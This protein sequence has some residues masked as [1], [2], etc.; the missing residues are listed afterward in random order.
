MDRAV[1]WA[2]SGTEWH[3][4]DGA[5]VASGDTEAGLLVTSTEFDDYEFQCEVWLAE[6]G[7]SGLFLRTQDIPADPAVHCLEFNLCDTHETYPT[8]SL[9][10]RAKAESV[11][12]IEGGWHVVSVRVEGE[13]FQGSIDGEVVLEAESPDFLKT[14][15]RRIG[16]QK[17]QGEVRFRDVK[18]RPL[19]LETVLST[20]SQEGWRTAPEGT[21]LS[22]T[23]E[24]EGVHLQGEGYYESERTYGDFVLQIEARLNA[25]DVNSGLFF[26]AEKST[27]DAPS[28]GYEMQMQNTIAEGDRTRPADYGDGFGTGAIFRRQRARYV[29]ASDKE[30][31]HITLVAQGNHFATWVN[32]LQVTDFVDDRET[33]SNPRQGRRDEAGHLSFQ[34]HDPATDITLR[35]VRVRS[36]EPAG[37]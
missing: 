8:G 31:M 22:V 1:R 7:N 10:G 20:K 19:G 36:L 4:S 35:S 6:G 24:D 15:G 21:N 29:N 12:K 17:N 28:N 37:S 11:S 13:K 16:L 9:V 30:W 5:I 25:A 34:G 27:P 18:L 23:P 33:H 26:R 32:G 2:N 14:G 3:I